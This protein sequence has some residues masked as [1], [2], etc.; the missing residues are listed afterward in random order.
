MSRVARTV[1]PWHLPWSM[2]NV[3]HATI[4]IIRGCNITCPAC[5][6]DPVSEVKP[7]EQVRAELET[8]TG[9]R[10]LSSLAVMGGEVLLHPRLADIVRMIKD[11]ALFVEVC[12]NGVLLDDAAV[13]ELKDAG[14]DIIYIHVEKGQERPDLKPDADAGQINALRAEKAALVAS[15]GL[16]VGL[17]MTAFSERSREIRDI[18]QFTIESPHVNY[19]LITLFR[20]VP[21][22]ESI[23]GDLY[24]GMHGRPEGDL[25]RFIA[26]GLSNDEIARFMRQEF[27]L[28]PFGCLGSNIDPADI[29][30]LSYLV[31]TNGREDD[32]ALYTGLVASAL[33]RLALWCIRRLSGRYPMYMGQNSSQFRMQLLLNGLLGGDL[34]RN[35]RFLLR[36]RSS[37]RLRAKR[38]LFQ[39]PANF[40]SD[41]RLIHCQSCPDAVIKDGHLVP[42]CIADRVSGTS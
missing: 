23:S 32:S 9:L 3:P 15:H 12:T 16:D 28:E 7:L 29:R 11:R 33:E 18:V 10:R 38:I 5:C 42:I 22:I 26:A 13:V 1:R 2:D 39:N 21:A 24:S 31:G 36:T 40:H 34:R 35:L 27:E 8:L 30:W 6:N 4:D 20:D 25:E 37:R 19:L 17:S 41:G 14:A